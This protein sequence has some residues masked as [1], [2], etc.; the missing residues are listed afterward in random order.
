M[1]EGKSMHACALSMDIHLPAC[2]SLKAKRSVVKRLV[3]GSRARFHVA[4]AEVGFQEQWQRTS[5]G[6][7]FVGGDASQV[8]Q[9]LDSVERFVWSWPEIN[10]LSSQRTW[11]DVSEP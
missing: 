4:A 9:V 5:L 2:T 7:A 10:V 8:E 11:L 6:F 3:E 1:A